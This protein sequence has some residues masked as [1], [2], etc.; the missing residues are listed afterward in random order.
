MIKPSKTTMEM[1]EQ[2][3]TNHKD[4]KDIYDL[5]KRTLIPPLNKSP[6]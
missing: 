5:N 1:A 2:L 4:K 6:W 3:H